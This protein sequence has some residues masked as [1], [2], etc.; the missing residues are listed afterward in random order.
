M[1]ADHRRACDDRL[2]L[3]DDRA[4][5]HRRSS[6]G[7]RRKIIQ[8]PS[9]AVVR[10]AVCERRR[11]DKIATV[12]LP[13]WA[14]ALDA[15]AIVM[16]ILAISVAVT[17]GF[18]TVIFD[19]RISVTDWWRPALWTLIALAV[20]HAIIRHDPLPQR[21]F[22]G[23]RGWWQSADKRII[24][25][26]HLS[27]RLGV[28]LV[29][30]LAVILIGFPPE[31]EKRWRIYSND[32]LDLPARWDTGWYLSIVTEG[33]RFNPGARADYQQN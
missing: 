6:T 12:K 28:I 18:R 32:F 16:A 11:R 9:R 23:L 10:Q 27:S 29:G 5:S 19:L 7:P 3:V 2:R 4:H 22:A 1:G 8:A 21:V 20:R 24:L 33:Y 31:A 26:I 30:F 25:P 15:V 13:V 17:G 14:K